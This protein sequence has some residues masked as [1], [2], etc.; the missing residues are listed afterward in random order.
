M[1]YDDDGFYI[2]RSFRTIKDNETGKEFKEK[3]EEKIKKY[4]PNS[5]LGTIEESFYDG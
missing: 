4:F 2:G 1:P 3:V 5:S